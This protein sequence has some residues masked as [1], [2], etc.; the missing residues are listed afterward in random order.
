MKEAD[1]TAA[2]I[3]IKTTKLGGVISGEHGIGLTKLKFI[4]Q[5]I[6]DDYADY[7]KEND[8]TDLF[9]PGKLRSDFPESKIY[10]PSLNL[11]EMEAFILEVSDM[12]DLTS[13]ISGC[14]RCGKCKEPCNT[15]HPSENMFYN[16]RNKILAVGLIAEAV[17]YE[18]QTAT[19]L[20]FR[21]FKMLREVSDYCTM[22]HNC[23]PPCPV[24]IDFG[25]VTL[26]LKKLLVDRKQKKVKPATALTLF[27]LK[28][29]GYYFNKLFRFLLLKFG[30][31]LQRLGY[32]FNKPVRK[33]SKKFVPY[34]HYIL[35]GKLLKS[36]EKSIREHLKLKG[37]SSFFAFQKP[38]S[39]VDKNVVYFAG[40]GSERMFSEISIATLALLYDAGVQVVIPPEYLC[41]GYPLKA[42]GQTKQAEIKSYENRVIFHKMQDT[43][44]YMHISDVVVSCGTC[45]EM[46]ST[47]QL[48]NIFPNA[49]L[50]DI[51]E[52]IDRE[53]LYPLIQEENKLF[54]H[55]PCH[56][57][58]KKQGYEK[59]F[60]NL[61]GT[62]PIAVPNCCGESGTM[63]LSTPEIS[64]SLREKKKSNF[65]E[66][67]KKREKAM[68]LT[69]CPSCVQ[70]LSRVHGKNALSGKSL[71]V[72]L[73]EKHLGKNWK[74]NFLK[75]VKKNNGIEKIMF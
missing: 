51:N 75:D 53:D 18:A 70:G 6:L 23:Y 8:P 12:K 32:T 25:N 40:C 37:N 48:E 29:R 72:Y 54:F 27:Y 65:V 66:H 5:S 22:C 34:I 63:A 21:N 14:V 60:N 49:G 59:T 20:S 35:S 33:I 3:M 64:Y 62:T 24:N 52:Y 2:L 9:N 69:S 31:S 44:G 16:P 56:S 15:S 45:Y 46:L 43:I 41:C 55:E 7:K 58:M 47:Y 36:G 42:N 10:T 50:I 73:A 17:L 71:V 30:F 1:E 57:P 61:L 26:A 74:K 13:S 38:G 4:D 67:L 39:T 11:L 28:R 68:V 19:N